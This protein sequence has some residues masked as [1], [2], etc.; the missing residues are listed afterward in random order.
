MLKENFKEQAKQ[1]VRQFY[2]EFIFIFINKTG[3]STLFSVNRPSE[4]ALEATPFFNID[5]TGYATAAGY[6]LWAPLS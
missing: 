3:C 1:E 2:K 6:S 4:T 5:K